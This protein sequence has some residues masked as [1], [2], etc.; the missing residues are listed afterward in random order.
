MLHVSVR[1]NAGKYQGI[2]PCTCGGTS[3]LLSESHDTFHC[4][5]IS[6]YISLSKII[7]NVIVVTEP[8]PGEQGDVGSFI[9]KRLDDADT[10]PSA[11]PHDSVHGFVYEGAGSTAGSLSSL[12]SAGGESEQDYN[13]LNDWGPRFNKLANMYGNEPADE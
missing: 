10:D 11:P 4:L 12:D 8:A 2:F 6:R 5:M 7:L 1:E 3:I 13:F 9:L